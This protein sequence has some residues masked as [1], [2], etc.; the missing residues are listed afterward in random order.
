MEIDVSGCEHFYQY[1]QCKNT[2][3]WFGTPCEWVDTKECTYKQLQ[4][5]MQENEGLQSLNDFNVQK[6]ETLQTENDELC[7][8]IRNELHDQYDK[9]VSEA[10][11]D[12]EWGVLDR[13]ATEAEFCKNVILETRNYIA[14]LKAENDELKQQI[15]TYAKVNEEDTKEWLKYK[16][17][18]D[19]IE[20]VLLSNYITSY[21]IG[22]MLEKI[23]ELKGNLSINK[24]AFNRICVEKYKL[25]QC[26][27]EIEEICKE[28][29][30]HDYDLCCTCKYADNCR[31]DDE[32][33]S[34]DVAN[35]IHSIIKQAKEGG[36]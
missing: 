13:N 15:K 12:I 17:C 20:E 8:A 10:E 27:D 36:E 5:L 22:T 24:D 28:C 31:A 29:H 26:L 33:T 21:D 14:K 16:Q 3:H 4:Q 6:I 30:K 23:K 7:T 34:Y 9:R 11:S 25:E 2:C 35:Y 19:Y 1:D 32:Y 18:F